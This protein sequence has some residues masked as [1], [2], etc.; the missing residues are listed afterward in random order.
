M[1]VK[2]RIEARAMAKVNSNLVITK[3]MV[4][5]KECVTQAEEEKLPS[6][7]GLRAVSTI[8]TILLKE[9]SDAQAY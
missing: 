6:A 7:K 5:L 1:G 3:H 4:D 2:E 9:R 8:L